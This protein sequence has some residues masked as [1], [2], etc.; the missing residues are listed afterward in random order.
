[1]KRRNAATDGQLIDGRYVYVVPASSSH[2]ATNS[3]LSSALRSRCRFCPA[4]GAQ[5]RCQPRSRWA[6]RCT[7]A[8]RVAHPRQWS[9]VL[10]L[11]RAAALRR[12]RCCCARRRVRSRG[13]MCRH[14]PRWALFVL[15][16]L[17]AL[18]W[19][20]CGAALR[21]RLDA[22]A[23]CAARAR[24]AG[25]CNYALRL[26]RGCVLSRAAPLPRSAARAA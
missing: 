15:R 19:R 23:P 5:W 3:A 25:D 14:A 24:R 8:R 21:P 7:P 26:A 16:K 18:R 6:S 17:Q 11:P 22:S 10:R 13:A 4:P 1:M 2:A 9:L 12:P 20:T